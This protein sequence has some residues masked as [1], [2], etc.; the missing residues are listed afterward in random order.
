MM[1]YLTG[2]IILGMS[3]GIVKH[4]LSSWNTIS[5]IPESLHWA[6]RRNEVCSRA[7]ACVRE[8]LAGH[9]TMASGYNEVSGLILDLYFV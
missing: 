3:I 4:L 6:G 8:L 5:D 2:F 9:R 1:E 7:R